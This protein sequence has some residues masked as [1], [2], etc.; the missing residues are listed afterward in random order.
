MNEIHDDRFDERDENQPHSNDEVI[1]IAKA[2]VKVPAIGL[3][4]TGIIVFVLIPLGVVNYFTLLPSQF[5]QAKKD[6]AKNQGK[7]PDA[8]KIANDVLDIYEKGLKV[9]LPIMWVVG[10]VT[11]A[12]TIIAGMK[13]KNLQ[14]PGLVKFGSIIS[15]IPCVSGCCVLGLIFGIWSLTTMGQP[16]VKAG[17]AAMKR[18]SQFAN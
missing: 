15:M 5:E 1:Q 12:L 18:R 9:A 4:V 16:E 2:R 10:G 11:A 7:N 6:L 3:I 17:F 8:D 14:S 13:L